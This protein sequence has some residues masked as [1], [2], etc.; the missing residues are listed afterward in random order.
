MKGV[1]VVL[2]SSLA[3]MSCATLV[4]TLQNSGPPFTFDVTSTAPDNLVQ[5]TVPSLE[6]VNRLTTGLQAVG[7]DIQVKNSS[8]KPLTIRW[9]ESSIDYN[10]KSHVVF[11]VGRYLS[12]AGR[13]MP[14]SHIS[15]GGDVI[16]GIVPASNVPSSSSAAYAPNQAPFEPMYSKNFTC[17]IAIY[18]GGEARVYVVNVVVGEKPQQ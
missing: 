3:L 6:T 4:K 18:L 17:R 10:G 12:D 1:I 2:C 13:D 7:A 15:P 16:T 5:V 14:D 8:D 9:R 11:L